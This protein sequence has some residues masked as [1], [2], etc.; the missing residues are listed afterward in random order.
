MKPTLAE[1]KRSLLEGAPKP[2]ELVPLQLDL[3]RKHPKEA[4]AA[5]ALIGAV[6][7]LSPKLRRVVID[8]VVG[9]SRSLL[10]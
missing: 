10:K 4:I 6:I 2:A 9:V 5:A 1:A 3:I 8:V 7:G